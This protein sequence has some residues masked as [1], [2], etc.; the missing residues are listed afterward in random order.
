MP[1]LCG[2]WCCGLADEVGFIAPAP[3]VV[4]AAL[5]LLLIGIDALLLP[6]AVWLSFWRRLAHPLHPSF[7]APGL[8]LLPAVLMV[9]RD[10]LL[11]VGL[12]HHC[13][14]WSLR[15]R[16]EGLKCTRSIT[17]NLKLLLPGGDL[18]G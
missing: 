13:R 2:R 9:A 7:Q 18:M 5:R 10:V 1:G 16:R 14:F 15:L 6:L 12:A 3:S 11:G 17:L 8:W 4:P